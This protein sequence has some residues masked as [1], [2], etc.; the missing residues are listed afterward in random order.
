LP[1]KIYSANIQKAFKT[2][3]WKLLMFLVLFLDVKLIVKLAAIV[4]M[5]LLQFNFKFGLRLHQSRLPVFYPAVIMIGLFSW[6]I[7]AGYTNTNYSFAFI[8]GIS[9]WMASLLAMHQVKLAVEQ[10]STAVIHQTLLVFFIMNAIVSIVFYFIIAFKSGTVNPY[11]YQ[12]EYQKYFIG[13]GDY[14]KG[15]SFD[16]STTNS[17]LNAFGVIYF[18]SRKNGFLMLLCMIILLLTGSNI[19]NLLLCA[20]LIFVLIF[21]SD[22][23]QKSLIFICLLLLVIF[24]TKVSPQNN[25]YVSNYLEQAFNISKEKTTENILLPISEKSDSS[26][27]SEER[28]EKVAILYLDSL[29]RL[30]NE[31]QKQ[32]IPK[33]VSFV[34]KPG[35]PTPDINT[36]P[37]QHKS[38]VTPVEKNM[39]QFIK[40]HSAELPISADSNYHPKFP[41]KIIAW[42]QTF[43]YLKQNPSKIISGAGIGNFSSKLAFKATSLNIAGGYPK[44]FTYMNSD[45]ISHHLDL[46]LFY[47]TKEDGLHS[48]TN[49]SNSVYD[50]LIT[51][52]GLLGVSAFLFFYIGFFLKKAKKLTYGI[53]LIFLLTGVFFFDYWFEQLSIVIVFE[54]LLFLNLKEEVKE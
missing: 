31:N 21:Q 34:E 18:L 30:R 3:D 7:T 16:T 50:Q 46:Y 28:K 22:K 36:P 23:A 19:T 41:G 15:I 51:E 10:N 43:N 37:Y 49:N 47:F 45:F 25:K 39:Q 35:I 52:Y 9:F 53:P 42:Q 33:T 8:T 38:I 54:L 6:M 12:G 20:T 17:V 14:I 48:I 27:T 44:K 11:L 32:L 26:L 29:Y 2:I 5:Y 40:A 24:L 13:S 1:Y 4:L